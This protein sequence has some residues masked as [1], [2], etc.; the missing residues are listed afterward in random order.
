VAEQ[1][2]LQQIVAQCRAVDLLKG[3]LPPGGVIADKLRQ[4]LRAGVGMEQD[5]LVVAV[6]KMGV[7]LVVRTVV[8]YT[9]WQIIFQVGFVE[10][11]VYRVPAD[12]DFDGDRFFGDD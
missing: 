9:H 10:I 11:V 8:V 12:K 3:L 1:T 2:T 5:V 4:V 6:I 7:E